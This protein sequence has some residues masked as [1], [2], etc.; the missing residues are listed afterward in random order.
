[1]IPENSKAN[2]ETLI[3]ATNAEQ[4]AL[5]ECQ[6]KATGKV[7]NAICA[8][9]FADGE[10]AFVPLAIMID[11]NPYELLN[12]PKPGG[13]FRGDTLTIKSTDE[14]LPYSPG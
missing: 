14:V 4:L 7:V 3:A 13:G 10:Y 9:N 1:M 2:F 11:G 5:L 8:I 12:P 6:E